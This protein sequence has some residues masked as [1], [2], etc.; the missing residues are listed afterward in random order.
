MVLEAIS[1]SGFR[2]FERVLEICLIQRHRGERFR[3]RELR[4]GNGLDEDAI[5]HRLEYESTL[6]MI[7]ADQLGGNDGPF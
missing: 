2:P 6:K 7:G 1:K 5:L 4:S 3:Q